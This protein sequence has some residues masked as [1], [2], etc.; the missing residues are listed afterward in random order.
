MFR[1]FSFS[2]FFSH[3]L[4]AIRYIT[5]S[6]SSSELT[7]VLQYEHFMR[8]IASASTLRSRSRRDRPLKWGACNA[9]KFGMLNRARFPLSK[10]LINYPRVLYPYYPR[11]CLPEPCI[12]A[13]P[14]ACSDHIFVVSSQR[15]VCESWLEMFLVLIIFDEVHMM[16]GRYWG[17]TPAFSCRN[18]TSWEQ[19]LGYLTRDRGPWTPT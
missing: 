3:S 13:R 1:D 4:A 17:S 14:M 6:W 10:R 15:A 2:S 7:S 12:G 5:T 9:R 19:S 8:R 16:I 11:S 18:C